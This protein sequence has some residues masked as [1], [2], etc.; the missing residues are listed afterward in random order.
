LTHDHPSLAVRVL[1]AEDHHVVRTALVALLRVEPDIDVVAEV[2]RGDKV[3]DAARR[4]R[5]DVALLD[6]EMPGMDGIDAA[7]A[8]RGVL[9]E[10]ATLVLTALAQP[11]HVLRALQHDVGGFIRKDAQ[12]QDLID[13]VRRVAAGHRVVDPVLVAEAVQLGRSPLTAR[14]TEVLEA[15]ARGLDTDEIATE[16]S[17]NVA[18]V[19]N[20]LSAVMAKLHARNRVDAIRIARESGWLDSAAT[21]S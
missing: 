6:L 7:V 19:R 8:L 2:D 12:D 18:T 4:A 21:D 1:V 17:L 10:C 13:A 15:A 20:Y 14:E 9:P 16:V 5:P 3:V 11:G